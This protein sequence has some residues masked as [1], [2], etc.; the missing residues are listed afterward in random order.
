[1]TRKGWILS[2]LCGFLL[3]FVIEL[4]STV[5]SYQNII[6]PKGMGTFPVYLMDFRIGEGSTTIELNS[7]ASTFMWL[8]LVP[9]LLAI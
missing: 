8:S 2:T 3:I 4:Y 6:I 9:L 5:N 7:F 1:M